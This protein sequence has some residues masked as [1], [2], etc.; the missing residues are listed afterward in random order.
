M[1]RIDVWL[2]KETREALEEKAHAEHK[3]MSAVA[4]ESLHDHAS[5]RCHPTQPIPKRPSF[6]GAG[7][8]GLTDV[9][10]RHDDYLAEDLQ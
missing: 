5:G 3:S 9:S 10:V 1:K 7:S 4:R 8:F 6:I 2:D